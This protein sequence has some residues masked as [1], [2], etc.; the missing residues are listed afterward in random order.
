MKYLLLISVIINIIVLIKLAAVRISLR[1]LR[2]DFSERKDL[3]SNT[4]LG[5]SGRDVQLRALA[6]DMNDTLSRL[7]ASYNRYE[8]GDRELKSA[9]T[10]IA[11]DLRTPLTAIC[12]YAE[13]AEWTDDPEL[14][15]KYLAI[16]AERA[17]YMKKLT[18]E[19][20]EYSVITGGE[21]SEEPQS[22][23]V[24][25]ILED[26]LMNYYPMFK[27]RGIDPKVSISEEGVERKLIRSY[28]ER[29]FSNLI[30]NALKYSDG[31]LEISLSEK[32]HL[33]IANSAAALN[34]VETEKL[35][36]R[37]F[38]VESARNS[39]AHGLGLSIVKIFTQRMGTPLLASY[40]NGKLV[41]E[42]DF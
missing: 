31:D 42:I 16:I 29:I 9:V 13:M 20:F 33:R 39:G 14:K 37:F 35:F 12:G 40:E 1:E 28:V 36:D 17:G 26:T 4:A 6:S 22:L 15:K 5:V 19:L 10:N 21:L 27:E 18:E 41:I 25:R 7:Q 34:N 8:R 30:G 3:R 32:G 11:H 2:R 24:D 23:R 38:T